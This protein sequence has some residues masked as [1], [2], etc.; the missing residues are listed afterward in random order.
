MREWHLLE[1]DESDDDHY[2]RESRRPAVTPVPSGNPSRAYVP[3][4]IIVNEI[5]D[6]IELYIP[7]R[8]EPIVYQSWNSAKN[9]AGYSVKDVFL[10]GEV[11]SPSYISARIRIDRSSHTGTFCLGSIQS[12]RARP[13]Q[14]RL[15]QP[16]QRICQCSYSPFLSF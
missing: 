14:R 1:P 5:P 11:R 9:M 13:T 7:G 2:R 12:H 16:V 4:G 15:H 8:R 6:A 3:D 10:T